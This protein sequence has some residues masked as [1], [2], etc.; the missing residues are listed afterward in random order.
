MCR[1]RKHPFEMVFGPLLSIAN[2]RATK[3]KWSNSEIVDLV[4]KS[5][6]QIPHLYTSI[7]NDAKSAGVKQNINFH[8]FF[9]H[10][11]DNCECCELLH[12]I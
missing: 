7:Q 10:H 8:I 4:I 2:A 1:L 9:Y 11:Y 3:K 12:L 6:Y 5:I